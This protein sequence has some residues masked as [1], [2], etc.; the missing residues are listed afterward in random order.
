[1]GSIPKN[2][3]PLIPPLKGALEG[4]RP[5]PPTEGKGDT[6]LPTAQGFGRRGDRVKQNY[7]NN[8]L[9]GNYV[10]D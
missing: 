5:I 7:M 10:T 4:L 6:G 9:A 8:A 3:T 2:L 1:M